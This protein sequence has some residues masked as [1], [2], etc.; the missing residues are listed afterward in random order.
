MIEIG[1]RELAF[2]CT[3]LLADSQEVVINA[4]LDGWQLKIT[5]V[6]YPQEE[7]G[8]NSVSW[9]AVSDNHAKI[10]FRGWDNSLGTA[11]KR[12]EKLG[13]TDTSRRLVS[14]MACN[15]KVGEI[16]RLDFQ[17]LLGGSDE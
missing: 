10:E 14:F 3:L 12:P 11:L 1:E 17:L 8:T 15:H 6:L 5:L 4:P 13:V 9:N 7:K 2:S 16:N